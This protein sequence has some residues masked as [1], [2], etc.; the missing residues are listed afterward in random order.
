MTLYS[1][2]TLA[3][4]ALVAVSMAAASGGETAGQESADEEG[5]KE[6]QARD[7]RAL[8]EQR[9]NDGLVILDV[10]TKAEFDDGHI[11]GSVN[12][13]YKDEAFKEKLSGLDTSA[14]YVVYCR[15]GRRSAEAAGIM[16]EMG[17]TDIYHLEE[18]VLGWQKA[19]LPVT[20]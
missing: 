16:E 18:G 17:F 7:A 11:N 2:I 6:I 15:S 10:R 4:A 12:L 3:A 9:K 8:I 1:I 19:G 13:D 5:I 14:T 20:R